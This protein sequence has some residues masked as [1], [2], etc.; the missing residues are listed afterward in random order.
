M[1]KVVFNFF[2]FLFVASQIH[3]Q[4]Y[5]SG[6]PEWLVD[7]FFS[8]SSFTDK[9]NYYSGEMLSE[10][11]EPTIGEELNGKGEIFFHQIKATNDENVFA[12]EIKLENKAID[13]Y[14]YLLKQESTWKINAIRR[15]LLPSFVYAVRDS[16]SKFKSLSSN[17]SAFYLSLKLF[18]MNDTDLK[19]YFNNNVNK[20]KQLV[21]YFNKELSDEVDKG[22]ASVNC[23][24]IYMDKKYPGC[25]F[26]QILTFENLES[27]FIY[28]D[29]SEVVPGVTANEFIYIEEVVPGWFIY[30]RM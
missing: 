4:Q 19:N 3:C 12:V 20:F 28:A 29:E 14:C 23:N 16:L 5:S 2:F 18:T 24:A 10:V 7:R 13:F 21:S 11:N 26:I 27:G 9:S 1:E 25:V 30:H 8:K 17:D 22:L 15:F 6:S